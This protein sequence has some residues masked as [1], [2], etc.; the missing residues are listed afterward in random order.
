MG[1]FANVLHTAARPIATHEFVEALRAVSPP[2]FSVSSSV[3]RRVGLA[4]SGGVDSMALAYLCTRLRSYN[5]YQFRIA[6]NP[7]H[8]FYGLVINH[9]VR[10]GSKQEAVAV[11]QALR[12]LG[13]RGTVFDLDF[14]KVAGES[15]NP[16]DMP[17]FESVARRLRYRKLGQACQAASIVS[18]LL[19]HHQDDQYETVMMRL[20][21]GHGVRGL[22]AIRSAADIPECEGMHGVDKSGYIDDQKQPRPF[23]NHMP[24]SAKMRR[25]RHELR[26]SISRLM[27]EQEDPSDDADPLESDYYG[28][29]DAIRTSRLV[30]L[31]STNID[32]E[33]G[34]LMMYRPL[35]EFPKARLIATCEAYKVPWWEDVTNHDGTVTMRNAV[36]H[37]VKYYNLPL[38]L[39]K[40]SILAL[41]RRCEKRAQALEAEAT[42]LLSRTI[43]HDV[44]PNAG[45]VSVQFPDYGPHLVRRD[46]SSHTRRRARIVRQREVAGLLIK[47]IIALVSPEEQTA[48]LPSLQNVITWLF[49]ALY[50]PEAS[51]RPDP[52]SPKA[53]SIAGLHFMPI[54]PDPK[55]RPGAAGLTWYASRAPYPSNVPA[56]Q[57]LIN[58]WSGAFGFKPRYK[59]TDYNWSRWTT[60]S[61]WDG[62]FWVRVTHRLPYRVL[63]LPFMKE[64]AKRFREQLPA[65]E[66][67]DRLAALLKRYAPGKTRY[68]LPALYLEED[69]DLL[70]PEPRLYYPLPPCSIKSL[71]HDEESGPEAEARRMGAGEATGTANG[72]YHQV[73]ANTDPNSR[74]PDVLDTSKLKLLAL[75]SLDVQ[76]PHLEDW[77]EYEIRFRRMD[78]GTMEKAGKYS[79]LKGCFL[80]GGDSPSS[81]LRFGRGRGRGR[82]SR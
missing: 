31:D 3:E 39:Q 1:T 48:S 19:A 70:R 5:P 47:K 72:G 37:M 81:A 42:R 16:L 15:Q 38:A 28:L 40:P 52:G 45:T 62:R 24:A 13:I 35:L 50:L 23:Y 82:R 67:R 25:L 57:V 76:V 34:G 20:L 9:G 21:Q 43:L 11:L 44:E 78:R 27:E 10:Q 8:D 79:Y 4:V 41:A 63:V 68:T 58:T 12:K 17:N 75:P 69:L 29:G 53:F 59:I 2:R 26:T 49:P 64:H 73:N 46:K 14:K 22:R 66:D 55:R 56:P 60:W 18:L 71:F 74:H 51:V 6:D 32:I 7:V 77:L 33:D 80:E 36:R 54:A 61:L 65:G 30:S